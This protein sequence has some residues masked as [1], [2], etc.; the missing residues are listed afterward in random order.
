MKKKE[1]PIYNRCTPYKMRKLLALAL[2]QCFFFSSSDEILAIKRGIY[3]SSWFLDSS[4]SVGG[5]L[6]SPY[7]EG[8]ICSLK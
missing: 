6:F 1:E 7:L 3:I 2:S 4:F 8:E 5:F